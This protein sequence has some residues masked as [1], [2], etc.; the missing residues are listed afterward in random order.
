[1]STRTTFQSVLAATRSAVHDDL[2][3]SARLP[4]RSEV[5]DRTVASGEP[6]GRQRAI[7]RPLRCRGGASRPGWCREHSRHSVIA[8]ACGIEHACATDRGLRRLVWRA[9][10]VLRANARRRPSSSIAWPLAGDVDGEVFERA[11]RNGEIGGLPP[12]ELQAT[13]GHR[14]VEVE[15]SDLGA[16]RRPARDCW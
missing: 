14:V 8:A 10:L 12:D 11:C 15:P 13:T 7:C 5:P 3:R 2:V 16:H 9:A 6:S 1:M 4:T